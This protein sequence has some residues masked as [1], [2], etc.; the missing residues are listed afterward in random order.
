MNILIVYL[1]G[2]E[3][4]RLAYQPKER[5]CN[6]TFN[7][8]LK[9]QR[10]DVAP[11]IAPMKYANRQQS[12]YGD[13]RK[14]Y[15]NLPTFIADSLPDSWG[16]E[17][18]EQWAKANKIPVAQASPLLKLMFIGKRGMGALEFEPA[19]TELNHCNAVDI[20][21][22]Y[23]LSLN[24]KHQRES[25]II[26]DVHDITM[27]SLISVGTSAGGRQMKAIVAINKETGEI[28]SGQVGG[29]DGFEYCIVKF[30]DTQFPSTEI[31]MA[32]YEMAIASG[33]SMEK[34]SILKADG[35]NHFLTRRFDR[36]DGEKVHMQ[37]LAAINPDA[38]TYEDLFATARELSLS[39]IEI[40]E[41]YRRLVFN[42]VTN[43]TDDHIKNFSFL[44]R[45]GGKWE[46][47]P[48]YDL[49]F[50][51]NR[52]ASAPDLN[53]CMSVV[54]KY[55]GLTCNYLAEFAKQNGVRNYKRIFETVLNAAKMFPTLAKK[56]GIPPKWANLIELTLRNN[57]FEMKFNA[58]LDTPHMLVD[59]N[60]R[61]FS[62][63]KISINTNGN[64]E[65]S[66]L[67]DGVRKR[68]FVRR[69]MK[70]FPL[71]QSIQFDN[72][73]DAEKLAIL[74]ELGV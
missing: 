23:D 69:G 11:L 70:L 24:I 72:L 66:L 73:S 45:K 71:F 4:G 34:C 2:T 22:L 14:I 43:N 46:L 27:Q 59:T 49:T 9:L 13:D 47:S 37:T 6:F 35:V 30:E 60:G 21:G 39:D 7:P 65:V 31:E 32:Y 74:E 41:L 28:R 29:L 3:L 1:W 42:V 63:I 54:G 52:F 64:F 20:K 67:I 33:I 51:F 40:E 68:R 18:F 55:S 56:Y 62:D 25:A 10:P 57:I 36:E 12:I 38:R 53:H 48:A 50:I 44:L 5:V 61:K 58:K 16:N 19:A 26:N 15:Q 8:A 17:L